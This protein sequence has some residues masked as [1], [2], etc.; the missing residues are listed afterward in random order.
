[1]KF[2]LECIERFC[3]KALIYVGIP[4]TDAAQAAEVVTQADH[5]G[6]LSHGLQRLPMYLTRIHDGAVNRRPRSANYPAIQSAWLS[7]EIM[8]WVL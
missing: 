3:K 4:E 6:V 2:T 7:T 5:S 1:M 8:A